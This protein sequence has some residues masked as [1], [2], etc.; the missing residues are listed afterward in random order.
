MTA[1]TYTCASPH[2]PIVPRRSARLVANLR[3]YSLVTISARTFA[4]VTLQ[5]MSKK[6]GGKVQDARCKSGGVKGPVVWQAKRKARS[7]PM[8]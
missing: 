7:T 5:Q 4:Y 2:D 1:H 6:K 8:P 3:G